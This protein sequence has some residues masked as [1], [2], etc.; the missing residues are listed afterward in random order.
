MAHGMPSWQ[1]VMH[2]RQIVPFLL[3]GGAERAF[4]FMLTLREAASRGDWCTAETQDIVVWLCGARQNKSTLIRTPTA[5]LKFSVPPPYK[6]NKTSGHGCLLMRHSLLCFQFGTVNL[7]ML[8]PFTI[9][10]EHFWVT[11]F[12]FFTLFNFSYSIE[13]W[14]YFNDYIIYFDVFFLHFYTPV[15]HCIYSLLGDLALPAL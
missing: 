13:I 11:H 14:I 6:N 4:E 2:R 5:A 3:P 1:G 15:I 9:K 8:M 7:T 12:T 10:Q